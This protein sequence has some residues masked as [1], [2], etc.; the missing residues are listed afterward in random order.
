MSVRALKQ[1]G[2]D[3]VD[4]DDVIAALPYIVRRDHRIVAGFAKKQQAVEWAQMRSYSDE[5]KFHVHTADEV[6]VA[7]QDGE[8]EEA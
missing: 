6:V 1:T 5:S 2:T 7:Y 3:L 8:E 4:L